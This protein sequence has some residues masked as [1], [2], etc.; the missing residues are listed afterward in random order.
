MSTDAIPAS[1]VPLSADQ[2]EAMLQRRLKKHDVAIVLLHWFNAATWILEVATGAAIIVSPYFRIAPQ[3]YTSL[4]EGIFGGRANLLT[5]HVAL[6]LTWI[7]VFL[8]YGIFGF[9][10]YLHH[11]VLRKEIALD[12]DDV[13]WLVVRSLDMLGRSKEPLPPQGSY[14]AGQKLFGLAVYSMVPVVMVTGLMMTFGWPSPAAVGWAVV[15]HFTAVGLVVSG[16]MI[17]VYM[18]AVFPEEKPAFFSMITGSVDEL[19]AYSHHF[20]WWREEKTRQLA[21]RAERDAALAAVASV[22]APDGTGRLETPS[23]GAGK[24]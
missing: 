8:V 6:G 24:A 4:V 15:L 16:L 20:K 1:P 2:A 21:R 3:W 18:A 9:R 19:Y 23:P 22:A 14:N 5:F 13:R 11:E 12:R 17:H 7:S 10:S